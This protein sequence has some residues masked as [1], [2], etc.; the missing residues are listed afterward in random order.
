MPS[1]NGSFR[2][3]LPSLSSGRFPRPPIGFT[4]RIHIAVGDADERTGEATAVI[5]FEVEKGVAKSM[6]FKERMKPSFTWNGL[7]E[8]ETDAESGRQPEKR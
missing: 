8:A 3:H 2:R 1:A 7:P 5:V 4:G 6:S